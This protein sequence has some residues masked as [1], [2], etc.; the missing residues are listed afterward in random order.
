MAVNRK[1]LIVDDD[2]NILMSLQMVLEDEGYEVLVA[3]SA[4]EALEI[5][6]T[7][8][9]PKVMYFD[10]HMPE[11]DGVEL[12]E[13]VRKTHQLALI[14]AMT[15]YTSIY[16]TASCRQAGFDDMFIKPFSIAQF[17]EVTRDSFKKI[18]RWFET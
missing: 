15:G 11:M 8:D 16:N 3:S 13:I 4:K 14:Y 5:L 17:R 10:L 12:C 2:K 7:G 18:D 6:K 9:N 1:V